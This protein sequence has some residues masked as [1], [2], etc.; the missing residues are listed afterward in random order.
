MLRAHVLATGVEPGDLHQLL[1]Q[2][3]EAADV[4][5]E[6]LGRPLRLGRHALELLREQRRLA[7]ERRHRRAQLVRH[8]RGEA[9]LA[10]LRLGQ[11]TD[12]LLERV[13]HLVERR[14]PGAELVVGLDGEPGVEQTLGERVRRRARLPD[15]AENP[16]GDE[17]AGGPGEDDHDAPP[18]KKDRPELREVVSQ[19][20]LGE[21]EV[22][23]GLRLWQLP[24][25]DQIGPFSDE[26]SL[27]GEVAVPY[28]ALHSGG[29]L[30]LSDR[31]ARRE[32][33]A[34]GQRNRLEARPPRVELE[35]AGDVLPRGRS[36][37]TAPASTKFVRVCASELSTESSRRELRTT[38]YV[39]SASAPVAIAATRAKVT[40]SRRLSLPVATTRLI[41]PARAGSRH[42]APS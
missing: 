25:G 7:D 26:Q 28:E 29:D 20:F 41:G 12:L 10:R 36:P 4:F 2:A 9:P 18:R 24:A 35:E 23:L 1:D 42:P 11:G 13:G 17:R 38:R 19:G 3:A 32:R 39:P 27:E 21:E 6:Q 22:E 14:R 16:A 37:S 34:A 40:A 5:H 30:H 31:E 15:R 33:P 8:V